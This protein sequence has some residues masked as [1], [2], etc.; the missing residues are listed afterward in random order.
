MEK[1]VKVGETPGGAKT[2]EELRVHGRVLSRALVS[3]EVP[4]PTPWPLLATWL[5]PRWGRWQ[6]VGVGVVLGPSSRCREANSRVR[7]LVENIG[8]RATLVKMF[9]KHRR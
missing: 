5:V 8:T 4:M 9:D 6:L 3:P 1:L 7:V 2:F